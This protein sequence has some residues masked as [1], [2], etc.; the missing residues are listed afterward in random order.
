MINWQTQEQLA[1]AILLQLT[2][3]P[4]NTP[5]EVLTVDEFFA[6]ATQEKDW[7]GQQE[8]ETCS[9][10]SIWLV[11]SNKAIAIPSPKAGY[12]RVRLFNLS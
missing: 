2:D 5:V 8:R 7:H 10:Y 6:I 3:D 1:P 11:P 4:A 9:G 12:K